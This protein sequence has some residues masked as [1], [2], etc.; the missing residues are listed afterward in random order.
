MR[1][2]K[3]FI[4]IFGGGSIGFWFFLII[5]VSI[6]AV[7]ISAISAKKQE[8]D[9]SNHGGLPLSAAVEAYRGYVQKVTLE[10]GIPDY[11]DLILADMM[12]ESGGKGTGDVMQSSDCGYNILYRGQ[13]IPDPY[14][15]IDCGVQ[16]MRDA[17]NAAGSTGK[18]DIPR[19]SLALQGY[20]FGLAYIPWALNHKDKG[21]THQNAE[22]Y[23]NLQLAIHN[24][25][26][27]KNP[28]TK[29]G[30]VDYVP[31]V[32]R[33][34]TDYIP[35]GVII[36][37][38]GYAFPVLS[39]W[40]ISQGYKGA[41]HTGIDIAAPEGTPVVAS[42]DGVVTMAQ[43][44]DGRT[45]TGMQSYGNCIDITGKTTGNVTR[46]AH[47]L[48]MD[49]RKGEEVPR[50]KII[51]YVGSTG[52]SY[53]PHC[54]FEYRPAPDHHYADPKIILLYYKEGN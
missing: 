4:L 2:I 39:N 12:Q 42:E 45:K 34:Y 50:G 26:Y 53:G 19:I 20:N 41:A 40:R 13:K 16:Y 3:K 10:Y 24:A 28:W 37:S 7:L 25:K 48:K 32:L 36:Y 21:Y 23:A 38:T 11:V 30:D 22:E 6:F 1:G 8:D 49:V 54:H 27:P 29:Y 51:G 5:I 14:Y 9:D 35:P 46:Y 47:L 44:W 18:D 15:S 33:Y 52:N 17:L 43:Q 31:H